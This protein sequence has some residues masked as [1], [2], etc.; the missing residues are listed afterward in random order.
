VA[1]AYKT[2]PPIQAENPPADPLLLLTGVG[3]GMHMLYWPDEFC[4]AP[5]DLRLPGAS[6]APLPTF[7]AGDSVLTSAS[8]E[9]SA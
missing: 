8:A 5:V 4:A 9:G 1:I 7:A 6:S 3:I 2:F